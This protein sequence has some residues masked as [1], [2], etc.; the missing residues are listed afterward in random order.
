MFKGAPADKITEPPETTGDR[1]SGTSKT[2]N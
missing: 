2:I 1:G